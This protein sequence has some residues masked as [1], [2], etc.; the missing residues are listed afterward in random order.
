MGI[1]LGVEHITQH[2]DQRGG[3]HRAHA[4]PQEAEADPWGLSLRQPVQVVAA[5]AHLLY[6]VVQGADHFHRI[7]YTEAGGPVAIAEI[8]HYA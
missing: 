2:P 1:G 6:Q 8:H 5:G 3:E 7:K 4:V